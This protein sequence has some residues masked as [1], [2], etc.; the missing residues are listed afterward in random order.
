M[1]I[2]KMHESQHYKDL[3]NYVIE[4][5]CD[6]FLLLDFRPYYNLS[7]L[8]SYGQLLSLFLFINFLITLGQLN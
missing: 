2:F 4:R 6:Y 8:R 1:D 5:F 7:D 3:N